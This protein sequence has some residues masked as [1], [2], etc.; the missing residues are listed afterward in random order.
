MLGPMWASPDD[1]VEL[2]VCVARLSRRERAWI[3][4]TCVNGR[5]S[6]L[7]YSGFLCSTDTHT[8]AWDLHCRPR[9]TVKTLTVCVAIG[10]L[11]DGCCLFCSFMLVRTSLDVCYV[12]TVC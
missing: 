12:T 5:V 6:V 7:R 9:T 11:C 4:V 10:F 2:T 8:T 3:C 1:D